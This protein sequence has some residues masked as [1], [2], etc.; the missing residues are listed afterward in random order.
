[1][2]KQYRIHKHLF[3]GFFGWVKGGG[4]TYLM[5][6]LT[7]V[8]PILPEI[9]DHCLYLN[10]TIHNFDT[11]NKHAIVL[12]YCRLSIK[13]KHSILYKG[14]KFWKF[15]ANLINFFLKWIHQIVLRLSTN[16]FL[17]VPTEYA[18]WPVLHSCFC[19]Y[20]FSFVLL[21]SLLCMFYVLFDH[22]NL[23]LM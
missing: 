20:S 8:S 23:A 14:A 6:Q 7:P 5:A 10:N 9:F 11:R 22:D 15:N 4:S 13:Q 12:P 21:V 3:S 18:T 1:M 2:T 19:F 16:I 17:S